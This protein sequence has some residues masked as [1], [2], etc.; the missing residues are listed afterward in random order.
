VG[1]RVSQVLLVCAL[2]SLAVPEGQE[3]AKRQGEQAGIAFQPLDDGFRACA[4]AQALAAI[5]GRL[6]ARDVWAFF[7]RW[8]R[9]LPSPFTR[10]DRR[11]GYRYQLAFRQ[12]EPSRDRRPLTTRPLLAQ[13]RARPRRSHPRRRPHRPRT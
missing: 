13:L 11:R 12:L 3:W 9:R 4:D 8:Q 1:P 5:C 2:P 10:E 7:R 6:S